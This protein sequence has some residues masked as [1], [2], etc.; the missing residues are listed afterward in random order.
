MQ[1]RSVY[2]RACKGIIKTIK[3]NI[4]CVTYRQGLI[5]ERFKGKDSWR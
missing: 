2:S 1:R 4:T 3:K 5:F